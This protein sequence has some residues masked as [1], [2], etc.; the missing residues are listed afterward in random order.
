MWFWCESASLNAKLESL[1]CFT[2][3]IFPSWVVWP[4]Y[5]TSMRVSGRPW[6]IRTSSHAG[7][8]SWMMW[9]QQ[10]CIDCW[11]PC[12]KQSR[13]FLIERCKKMD[14]LN[15]LLLPFAGDKNGRKITVMWDWLQWLV[16]AAFVLQACLQTVGSWTCVFVCVCVCVCPCKFKPKEMDFKHKPIHDS[17]VILPAWP[18]QLSVSILQLLC[19]KILDLIWYRLSHREE[20]INLPLSQKHV[21]QHHAIRDLRWSISTHKHLINDVWISA[22]EEWW[23]LTLHC[24]VCSAHAPQRLMWVVS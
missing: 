14:C 3:V 21:L 15:C 18:L 12:H 1:R 17:C 22:L 7:P 5:R 8:R 4:L 9:I 24:S 23:L 11:P 20:P 2:K 16:L 10:K 19:H 13:S 6:S